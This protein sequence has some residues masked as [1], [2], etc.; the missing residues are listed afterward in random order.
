MNILH[1]FTCLLVAVSFAAAESPKPVD[2]EAI[3]HKVTLSLGQDFSIK[4]KRDG[5][6]LVEPAKVA[7]SDEKAQTVQIKLDVTTASPVPGPTKGATRPYVHVANH[8]DST[9]HYRMLVRNKGSKEFFETANGVRPLEAE[10]VANHCWNFDSLIEEVVVFDFA[11]SPPAKAKADGEREKK[12]QFKGVELYS[13]KDKDGNW[14]FVLANGTNRQKNVGEI[15]EERLKIKGVAELK[16]SLA[17]LAEREYVV[18]S[19]HRL[20]GFE[21]PPKDTLKD[22]A[23]AAGESKIELVI[24]VE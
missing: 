10:G 11:L 18:W 22:V 23:K 9:L 5:D 2:V 21:F 13:W 19:A 20:P 1:S 17:L 6:K 15:K 12:V 3:K 24:A 8:M 14:V 7:A 16:K 4:F